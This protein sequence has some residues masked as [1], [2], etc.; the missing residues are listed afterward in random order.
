MQRDGG[1]IEGRYESG[2]GDETTRS[3]ATNAFILESILYRQAGTLH[4][5]VVVPLRAS[6]CVDPGAVGTQP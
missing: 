2:S 4:P 6:K 1:W 5:V 3:A